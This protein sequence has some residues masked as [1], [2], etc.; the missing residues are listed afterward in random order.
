MGK[1]TDLNVTGKEKGAF[2]ADL[3]ISNE[4]LV[5]GILLRLGFDVGVMQVTRTPFDL[6]L[7]AFEK[8]KGLK[9]ALRVQIK[10]IS[11]GDSIKLGGGAR[12]GID[13][14]YKSGVKEYKYTTEHNDLII[15]VDRNTF[16]LYLVPTSFIVKWGKSKSVRGLA[17]LKNNWDLLMNWNNQYLSEIESNLE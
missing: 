4:F 13:R 8:P 14:E 9:I 10:T 11:K 12:G 17:L 1:I 7:Y 5:T 2:A 3:G 6:W 15:G 16:D